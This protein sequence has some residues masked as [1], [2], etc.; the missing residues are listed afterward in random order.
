MI[1]ISQIKPAIQNFQIT[2]DRFPASLDELVSKGYL[3]QIPAAPYGMKLQYDPKT[4]AVSMEK[5]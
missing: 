4:G 2:E 5:M 3:R 1:D